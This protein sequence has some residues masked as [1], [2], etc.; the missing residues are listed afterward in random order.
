[1]KLKVHE[2]GICGVIEPLGGEQ[3]MF[4]VTNIYKME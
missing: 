4:R 3:V 1:M 2:K